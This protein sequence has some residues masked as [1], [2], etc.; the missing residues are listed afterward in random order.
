MQPRMKAS[1]R[2]RARLS[3]ADRIA[4]GESAST[5]GGGGDGASVLDSGFGESASVLAGGAAAGGDGEESP[6]DTNT[7]LQLIFSYYCKFGRTGG[8]GD[9]QDTLDNANFSKFARE[10]PDLMDRVL[11]ATGE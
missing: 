1:E 9:E 3:S 8:A 11:N 6:L 5:Y 10:C 2:T 7:Q 4:L